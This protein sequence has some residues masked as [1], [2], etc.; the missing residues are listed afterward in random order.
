MVIDVHVIKGWNEDIAPDRIVIDV[1]FHRSFI[2]LAGRCYI[3]PE[4]EKARND[5][6]LPVHDGPQR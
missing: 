1:G 6:Y 4:Q 3:T 2:N 5:G